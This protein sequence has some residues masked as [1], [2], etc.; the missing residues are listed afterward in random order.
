MGTYDAYWEMN[1]EAVERRQNELK[2]T[3]WIIRDANKKDIVKPKE[4]LT[5]EEAWKAVVDPPFSKED[6]QKKGYCA[7]R[8]DVTKLKQE[9][10]TMQSRGYL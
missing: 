8:I 3:F 6:Y 5:E 7:V 10:E 2:N 1:E 9:Y 4:Y